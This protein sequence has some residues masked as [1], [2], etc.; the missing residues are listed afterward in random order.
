MSLRVLIVDDE[1][2]ARRRVA[3]MLEGEPDLQVVG[4]AADGL[5]A[6]EKIKSLSPDL[7]FLDIQMA[8]ADGFDVVREVGPEAM[9]L[10]VFATAYDEYAVRAFEAQ[11]LDY[12][13]KPFDEER[14]RRAL[15]RAREELQTQNLA[16][17]G[18]LRA[19]VEALPSRPAHLRRLVV[20]SEGRVVFLRIGEIDW[21]EAS[22]NYVLIHAGKST[23][24]VRETMGALETKLDP[25]SFLRIHRSTIVNLD[26]V[27]ELHAWFAGEQLLELKDGTKLTVGRAFR[28]RLQ[29]L[30]DN[31]VEQA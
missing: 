17:I 2:W 7:V 19:L 16:R 6:I 27:K 29:R 22:R 28:D 8:E 1:P 3:A 26:R 5:E 31:A 15:G 4:E 11:A 14:L 12:L 21:L 10:V 13:L 20:K 25:D 30:I 18:K 24:M 23:Y 9:P